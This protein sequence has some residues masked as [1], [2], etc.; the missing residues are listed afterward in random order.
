MPRGEDAPRGPVR[1]CAGCRS[2]QPAAA[3]VRLAV[4]PEAPWLV[5]D[6]K[7]RLGGRGVWV[8]PRPA[9]LQAAARKGGFARSL[10]RKVT[11]DPAALADAIERG[12]RERLQGL[13][14]GARRGG[15]LAIG[16]EAAKTSVREGK[17]R[18]LWVAEDAGR[19]HD[20]E[21]QAQRLGS[22]CLVWGTR[23][24]LGELFGREA[25]AVCAVEDEGL[26][27]AL[28]GVTEQLSSLREQEGLRGGGASPHNGTRRARPGHREA[29]E[30]H[31]ADDREDPAVT[32]HEAREAPSAAGRRTGSEHE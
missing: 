16:T 30:S 7:G 10:R 3:M 1:T 21:H 31:V 17:T 27:E 18:L 5:P 13:V 29:L 25:V 8:H 20:L 14:L 26:A 23:D 12:L 24:T 11:V 19:R 2:A 28:R 15:H 4:V 9:C 6:P 32:G 22:A